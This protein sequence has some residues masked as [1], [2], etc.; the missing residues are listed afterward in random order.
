MGHI[1]QLT[2]SLSITS[3]DEHAIGVWNENDFLTEK[4]DS[5]KFLLSLKT[6]TI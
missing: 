3:I 5:I 6:T 2:K 1:F 4:V